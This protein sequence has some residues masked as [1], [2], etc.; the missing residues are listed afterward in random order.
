MW[1]YLG[2]NQLLVIHL[3]YTNSPHSGAKLSV[4]VENASNFDRVEVT[5]N[6]DSR[7]L[8]FNGTTTFSLPS[9]NKKGSGVVRVY[10]GAGVM[11]REGDFTFKDIGAEQKWIVTDGGIN[12]RCFS[13]IFSNSSIIEQ[14]KPWKFTQM[15][16][17][18]SS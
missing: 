8:S 7:T 18:T 1:S 16:D 14:S 3:I 2:G 10:D 6:G 9:G 15:T 17:K 13:R 11:V 12:Y 4:T 5:I